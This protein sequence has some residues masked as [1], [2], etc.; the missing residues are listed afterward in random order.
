[1]V[2]FEGHIDR[3]NGVTIKSEEESCSDTDFTQKLEGNSN[4]WVFC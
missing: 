1:M 4:I 3:Y 2:S